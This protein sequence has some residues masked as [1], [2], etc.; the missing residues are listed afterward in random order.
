MTGLSRSVTVVLLLSSL[1]QAL[2]A[3]A[4]EAEAGG[5]PLGPFGT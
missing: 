4:N 3:R 2:G 5:L 1:L